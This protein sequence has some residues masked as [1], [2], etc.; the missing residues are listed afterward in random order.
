MRSLI[1]LRSF[2]DVIVGVAF[3]LSILAVGLLAFPG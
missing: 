2:P 3:L 1:Q